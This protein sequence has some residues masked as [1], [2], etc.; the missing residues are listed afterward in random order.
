MARGDLFV[1][2]D[3]LA[4]MLDGGWEAADEIWIGLVTDDPVN[5]NDDV[6]AYVVGGTTNYAAV[7]AGGNYALG[8]FLLAT[9]GNMIVEV[10]GVMTFDDTDASV[11]WDQDPANPDTAEWAI[12]Y[13][14]TQ[15]NFAIAA[16]DLDGPII[17][18]AGDLTIT[19][20]GS[21]IFTIS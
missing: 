21:G 18:T 14:D 4:Y 1:F 13:N 7:V 20:N 6:P 9:W 8:G 11:T 12:I 16:I 10:G 3:A 15:A 17:M 5:V 2:D 19:W